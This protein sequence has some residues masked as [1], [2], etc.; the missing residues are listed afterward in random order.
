[1]RVIF[2]A[3]LI[4]PV[5]VAA[6]DERFGKWAKLK[7]PAAGPAAS[8]GSYSAGCLTGAE[9]LPLD[10]A[11][12]SL[13]RV[14]RQRRYAHPILTTYLNDLS[15]NLK[16]QHLP[17]MLVGDASP[18][19]GGPMATGHNSHQTGL[20]VDIWLRM[21][22]KR[23]TKKQR[24][25][26][27]ATRFVRDRKT[28]LGTWSSVQEKLVATATASDAVS[29]VFVAPAIKKYFCEKSPEAPWLYRLR[30]W[31]GHEEHLHVRLHCPPGTSGCVAQPPL[32]PADNGC[33]SELDWWFSKEADEEWEKLKNSTDERAFPDLPAECQALVD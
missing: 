25:T 28:L 5:S 15:Q 32:N 18:P 27:G 6:L 3:L 9:R 4:G 19:R 26:W 29:R 13:M 10:G 21:N 24:E 23:P 16:R 22:S 1:M 20:D 14:S 7:N 30:A 31:W 12:Y 11:H 8:I 33:G 17:F 2:I